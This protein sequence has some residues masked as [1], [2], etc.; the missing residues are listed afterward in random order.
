MFP[1]CEPLKKALPPF[2]EQLK[3]FSLSYSVVCLL[4]PACF[5]LAVHRLDFHFVQSRCQTFSGRAG[6]LLLACFFVWPFL[7]LTCSQQAVFRPEEK[8][9]TF[10]SIQRFR[11]GLTGSALCDGELFTH[12]LLKTGFSFLLFSLKCFQEKIILL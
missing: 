3:T 4:D 6:R 1:S 8:L 5:L 9:N 2:F 12:V 10:E 11:Q 7:L